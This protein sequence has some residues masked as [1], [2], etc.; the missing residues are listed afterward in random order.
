[1]DRK[2]HLLG[3]FLSA[4]LATVGMHVWRGHALAGDQ[5]AAGPEY[6]SAATGR[7]NMLRNHAKKKK[8]KKK[9][10]NPERQP[11]PPSTVQLA[12]AAL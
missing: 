2:V 10:A 8:K 4:H 3:V 6:L 5:V 12:A 1:M 11:P 9:K 7:F